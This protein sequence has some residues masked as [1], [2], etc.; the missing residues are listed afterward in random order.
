[1][2]A[3][4]WLF[5]VYVYL[6]H[7]LWYMTVHDFVC[8]QGLREGMDLLD[9]DMNREDGCSSAHDCKYDLDILPSLFFCHVCRRLCFCMFG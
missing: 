5:S 1:M 9:A 7:R 8:H 6:V 3:V 2:S 4:L